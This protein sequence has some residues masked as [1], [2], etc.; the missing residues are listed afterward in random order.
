MT[1]DG[2]DLGSVAI[3]TTGLIAV[4][5]PVTAQLAWLGFLAAAFMAS[6]WTDVEDEPT[7]R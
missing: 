1:A 2:V 6:R 7:R 5:V 3:I 4:S